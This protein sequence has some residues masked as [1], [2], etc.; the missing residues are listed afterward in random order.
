MRRSP[1]QDT[2]RSVRLISRRGGLLVGG[3]QL[4]FAGG[5]L[6]GGRMRYLQVDQADR[7]RTLAEENRIAF[8]LIPPRA[9]VD[10]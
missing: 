4:G 3:L 8:E 7:Y 2:D 10:L 9:R 6:L 1:P 5:V